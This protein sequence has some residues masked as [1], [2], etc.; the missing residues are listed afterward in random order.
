MD[1]HFKIS[2]AASRSGLTVKT[3]RYYEEIGLIGPFQRKGDDWTS[4]P[5]RRIFSEGDIERLIFIKQARAMDLSLDQIKVLLD[6]MAAGCGCK[7]RPLLKTFIESKCGQISERIQDLESLREKLGALHTRTADRIN[8]KLPLGQQT[9][10]MAKIIFGDA[11]AP[12]EEI[13]PQPITFTKN[14]SLRRLMSKKR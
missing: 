10:G 13:K 7:I 11:S 2:E 9:S 4:S 5:G 3:I 1:K 8:E 6:S 14:P 12:R